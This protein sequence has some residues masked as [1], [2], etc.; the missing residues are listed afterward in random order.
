[1]LRSLAKFVLRAVARVLFRVRVE[2]CMPAPQDRLLVI[3]NHESL[4]DGLLL[5]L[6]LPL[7]PVFVVH[8]TVIRNPFYRLVL[9]LVDHLTVDP[10]SPMAMKRVVRLLES[11]R[12]VVIF[13][14]GRITTTGS[15]MKTYDGP[16][17]VAARTG[18]TLLPVRIDGA[19]RTYFSRLDGR[20]P[21]RLLPQ[22]SLY[23]QPTTR[24]EM[25]AAPTARERRR[26]AGEAM[27]RIMQEMIFASRP[28]QTLFEA[29]LDTA[30]I[31]G[32][33]RRLVED[34]K[35]QE[36]SYA[37]LV[38]MALALGRLVE[39]ETAPDENVGVLLPNLAPTLAL[40]FGLSA[41]RRVPA[42][43]NY[44]A[45]VEG[46][47]AACDAARIRTVITSRAFVEQAK[48]G[49]KLAALHDLRVLYLEDLRA[50]MKLADKL[51]LLLWAAHFPRAASHIGDA[52]DPAVVLFT[53]GSEG[54]PKGV[55]LS[56]RALLANI[57]QIRAVVDFSVDDKVLNALPLFHSFGL[58]AGGLLPVLCGARVF[59]YPSPL[60]YRVIPELAYDRACTVL[61]GTS[62]FL[63]NYA[64]HAHP[65]DFHRLRYVIA[66]AEKLAELVREQW[67]DKFGIRIFEGYGA[68]ETAPVIAVNTPMAFRRGTVGQVLPGLHARLVPVPGIDADGGRRGML[69]VSGP[70]LMSGYLK[71]D[72]PGVLQAPASE[73]GEG[74]YDTGD[75]VE[76][77]DEGF[78]RIV[79]RVK[80]F[81]K[82]A[83]EMVSLEVVEK[84]AA[85]AS[86]AAQ[87]AASSR[88]DEGKGE[89]LVLFTTDRA[90]TREALAAAARASGASE[91]A[92]PRILVGVE[93]L[94]L[95]GTG[96]IDHVIL[97]QRAEAA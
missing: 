62:T 63:G 97:K 58:T 53:S 52:E 92:V 79:G 54:K 85:T 73:I 48:L 34:L 60:H 56:H 83:G 15:L 42:M 59:L 49:D 21:R 74:W 81:A 32:R 86:P 47:Q 90:L 20:Y 89:A 87:H 61:L 6:F 88:P 46:M 50:N 64:R 68:T 84:I 39:R 22:I 33:S 45:G 29:L 24:I 13:P 67:F 8:T 94:P 25:P 40:V 14:E 31:Q 36:Y 3:A 5:G 75:V 2:G 51:W 65:Y 26:K 44:T 69:H 23:I 27:R 11:G 57:A 41:R 66:G 80:R 96:K 37:E 17:F 91:L 77:D 7:D 30:A 82:I 95:L 28:R 1:M 18:A 93:T 78:V 43:L 55:V 38:R 9:M 76:I 70:N 72:A 10:T 12:P 35:R 4:L 16:A 19:A 71:A